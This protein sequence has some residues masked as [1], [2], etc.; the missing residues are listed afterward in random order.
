MT[1]V[2]I[3]HYIPGIADVFVLD[4]EFG[5]KEKAESFI[6]RAGWPLAPNPVLPSSYAVIVN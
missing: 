6:R 2:Q 5:S 3:R 4:R 1:T